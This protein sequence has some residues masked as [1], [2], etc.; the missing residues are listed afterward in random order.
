VA[1]ESLAARLGPRL[2]LSPQAFL[3]A[4]PD[5]PATAAEPE[6]VAEDEIAP[7]EE[8]DQTI[9]LLLHAALV[10]A[11]TRQWLAGQDATVLAGRPGL[12]LLQKCLGATF[13]PSDPAATQA[14]LAAQPPE[15]QS[16]L[17]ALLMGRPPADPGA[18]ARD[19]LRSLRRQ[20]LETRRA[21][22]NARLRQTGLPPAEVGRLQAEVV[23]IMQEI[24]Q[25]S[26]SH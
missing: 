16:V 5:Q 25:I 24:G 6:E 7:T 3:E 19:T 18:I 10:N 26:G 12:S 21:A 22:L 8:P 20:Q 15:A 14:F 4:I 11:E 9:R 2:T 1:R 23:D 13:D 17:A